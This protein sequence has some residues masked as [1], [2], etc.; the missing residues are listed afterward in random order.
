[1]DDLRDP[2]LHTPSL[3][4]YLDRPMSD[5]FK[6]FNNDVG[7]VGGSDDLR[8]LVVGSFP[9]ALKT[10]DT[11]KEMNIDTLASKIKV[12]KQLCENNKSNA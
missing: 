12:I 5:L 11:M 8:T 4:K 6:E 7:A 2:D 3:M 1:M 10:L 9:V